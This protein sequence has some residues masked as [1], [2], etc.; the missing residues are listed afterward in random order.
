MD[1]SE[2]LIVEIF[3]IICIIFKREVHLDNTFEDEN[4]VFLEWWGDD[5]RD[6][7]IVECSYV[8]LYHCRGDLITTKSGDDSSHVI[9]EVYSYRK[10][11]VS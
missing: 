1:L 4:K 2:K 9:S 11:H 10:L 3:D 8:P 6:E 5:G 7:S